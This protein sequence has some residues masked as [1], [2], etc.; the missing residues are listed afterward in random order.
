MKTIQKLVLIS[1]TIFFL[2]SCSDDDS[3]EVT[4]TLVKTFNVALSAQFSVP[5]N[6]ARNETGTA[7][8]NLYDDNSLEYNITVDG[9]SSSDA[10]TAAH[11][12][13]GDLVSTGGILI[14]LAG[15]DNASFSG[16]TVSD[17][18]ILNAEQV[19]SLNGSDIYV[20]VHSNEIGSGL[21]RGQVDKIIDF[22]VDVN[23]STANAVPAVTGRNETGITYIRL[24]S[25]GNM[26]YKISINDLDATDSLTASHIHQATAG[27]TGGVL[28]LLVDGANAATDYGVSKSLALTNDQKTI[29]LNDALYV[30]TH[31]VQNAPGLLR[32]QIR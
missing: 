11:I 29:L 1:L 24:D 6:A 15:G 21:V 30:N 22:A 2:N 10:L 28:V 16:S 7:V 31:S 4:K 8:L 18:I 19:A 25:E 20:N 27:N 32:G 3:N 14:G 5:A 13:T 17:T 23:M 26:Y 12:H 9:L